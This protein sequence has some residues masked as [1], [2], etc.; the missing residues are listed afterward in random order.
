LC[1][2]AGGGGAE[3]LKKRFGVEAYYGL[4]IGIKNTDDFIINI[5]K[6][7]GLEIPDRL[8][9]ERGRLIDAIVDT[10][11]YT[12]GKRVGIFGD[13]KCFLLTRWGVV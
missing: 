2:H 7:T 10:V 11:H 13:N 6:V 1:Q 3:F 4:P 9:D 5:A 12:M 8:L